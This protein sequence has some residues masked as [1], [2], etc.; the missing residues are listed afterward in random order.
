MSRIGLQ[1]VV[2]PKGVTVT[3][4]DNLLHVKGS[5][6]ELTQT[7]NP[8]ISF[9]VGDEEV[10]VN[11]GN[12]SKKARSMHGLYRSLLNNMVNG[13]SQGY[14]KTLVIN[15]VGYRA[16]LNGKVLMLNLGF[17]NQ[18]E[19]LTPEGVDLS[20]EGNNKVSVSG[21]D[22]AIV[23][24]VAA[25]I[26]KLRPPEPYKGKGIRYDNENVRRKVGKSGVK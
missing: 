23:G 11:R 10:Q 16:E 15:G 9:T 24:Q 3:V 18:V 17:S 5:K 4:K 7:F 19:Y 14:T 1:P 12:D 6:G 22:K 21:I 13:V 26:R 25:E 8:L 20:V 2:V